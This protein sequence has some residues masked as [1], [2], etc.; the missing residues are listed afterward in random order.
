MNDNI[1]KLYEELLERMKELES[2]K[3]ST[4]TDARITELSLVIIRVQQILL[5]SI[6]LKNK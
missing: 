1:E 5:D 2:R 6:R 4:I 3:Q